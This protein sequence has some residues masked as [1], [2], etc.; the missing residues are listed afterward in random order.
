MKRNLSGWGVTIAGL[1]LAAA[2]AWAM[3]TGWDMILIE[4]GWSLFIA[5]AVAVSGG[6]VT[7]ALGRVVASLSRLAERPV[8]V[9]APE[10]EAVV[11]AEPPPA[12]TPRPVA[13]APTLPPEPIPA[14]APAPVVEEPREP[15]PP[16]ILRQRYGY[17]RGTPPLART[18]VEPAPAPEP[19]TEVDR[20]TSGGATYVMLSDGSVEVHGPNGVRRY[21]SLALLKAEAAL[22]SL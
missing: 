13:P 11:V 21:A 16:P 19:P 17:S 2:G 6:V 12:A 22:H 5:G 20:Y 15:S 3:W 7:V 18:P 8:A 9:A 1:L 14:P 10:T 4:R